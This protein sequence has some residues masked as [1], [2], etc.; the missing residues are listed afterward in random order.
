MG[1]TLA[2]HPLAEKL[3]NCDLVKSV[4]TVLEVLQDQAQAFTKSLKGIVAD[5][6]CSDFI[7]S[8]IHIS[9]ISWAGSGL[10]SF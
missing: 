1:T 10:V 9:N 8:S 4:I 2:S 7:E 5:F 6:D 3:Q